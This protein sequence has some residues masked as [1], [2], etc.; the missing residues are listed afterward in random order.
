MLS[1]VVAF[2]AAVLDCLC[3]DRGYEGEE[4]EGWFGEHREFI[5]VEDLDGGNV[6]FGGDE[7]WN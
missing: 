5:F 4:E 2:Y 7:G 1:K 3:R 6:S